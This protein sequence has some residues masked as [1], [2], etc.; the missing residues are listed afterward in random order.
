MLASIAMYA[1]IPMPCLNQSRSRFSVVSAVLCVW[2]AR[3]LKLSP[4]P[5]S[6]N[7]GPTSEGRGKEGKREEG[8]KEVERDGGKEKGKE[9]TGEGGDSNPPSHVWLRG[10]VSKSGNHSSFNTVL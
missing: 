6:C 4:R 3:E 1:A 2:H 7:M 8:G 9:G 5:P 10:L